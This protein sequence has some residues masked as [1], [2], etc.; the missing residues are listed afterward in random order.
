MSLSFLLAVTLS[1]TPPPPIPAV[2][3]DHPGD[4]GDPES[5]RELWESGRSWASFLE[6]AESRRDLWIENWAGSE[7]LDGELAERVREAGGSWYILAVAIDACSDSVSTIPYLARLAD[8][9]DGLELRI[10][11]SDAG[12]WIMEEN[13]TPDG[14]PATPTVV[15]LDPDFK[16]RGCFIERPG[17][18][19]TRLLENPDDLDQRGLYDFK[20]EWYSDDAGAT[21]AAEFVE[22]LEAAAEGGVRCG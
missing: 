18:L 21:T 12:A 13:R 7:A 9:V 6:A 16:K 3:L 19:Q 22:I 10:V 17:P 2:C 1:V 14:R 20:M 15:L 8:R 5:Y 11:D 4:P